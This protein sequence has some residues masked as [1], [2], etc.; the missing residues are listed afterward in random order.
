MV[1]LQQFNAFGLI[2]VEPQHLLAFIVAVADNGQRFEK[3][4]Q[5]DLTAP[6]SGLA[7][8]NCLI[9]FAADLKG[10]TSAKIAAKQLGTSA[11]SPDITTTQPLVDFFNLIISEMTTTVG[12]KNN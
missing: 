4:V 6:V 5:K 9:S 2:K 12:W 8:G 1:Q 10:G 11:N 3:T 7:G